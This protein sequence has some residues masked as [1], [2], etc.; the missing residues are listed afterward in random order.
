MTAHGQL[1]WDFG[2]DSTGALCSFWRSFLTS[3]PNW[4][5]SWLDR[6]TRTISPSA[7]RSPSCRS[8]TGLFWLRIPSCAWHG[9]AGSFANSFCMFSAKHGRI[10]RFCGWQGLNSHISRLMTY[11]AWISNHRARH[12]APIKGEL[13]RWVYTTL[14][15]WG[16]PKYKHG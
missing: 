1:I 6:E 4:K 13:F 8:C 10:L 16:L 7:C 15:S 3:T 5:K 2:A 14:F 12:W 11:T 9:M